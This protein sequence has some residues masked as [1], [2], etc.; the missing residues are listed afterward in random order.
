LADKILIT[1]G[2]GF[3]G[4]HLVEHMVLNGYEVVVYDRYNSESNY[5]WLEESQVKK[6]VK[7]I[8]G[9]IRDFDSVYNA[10]NQVD[11]II[12][13]AALIGIPYSY[14]SPLAYLKTNTEGTYNIL[15]SAKKLN[16]SNITITSTSEVY[17]SAKYSPIDEDH[18][19][20]AQS[21]YSASKISA[22]H[23]AFS[24]FNSYNLPIKV[25]R[26][27]NTYGPRQSKR[28]IIPTI[29]SQFLND[30]DTVKL[31][32]LDPIRDFT[33]VSDTCNGFEKIYKEQKAIGKV[34]NLGSNNE[35]SINEVVKLVSKLTKITKKIDIDNSRV[36]P[37]KSEVNHLNCDYT[38]FNNLVKWEPT[39]KFENGLLKTI[40]WISCRKNYLNSNDYKI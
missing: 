10:V 40:D 23:L 30:S 24:Y 4:S 22:D 33:Y 37:E 18:P 16:S 5:G 6:D 7:I 1:G 27:F 29:I 28:A 38:K 34:F 12:H 20:Q 36:R 19:L 13:L 14:E 17:G 35:I 32:S 21:P 8:L 2:C 31:G 3:I 11:S 39:I 25:L 9:D 26:P 15:E